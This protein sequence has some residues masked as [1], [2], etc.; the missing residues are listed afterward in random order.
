MEA[1]AWDAKYVHILNAASEN[2]FVKRLIV[3]HKD[4]HDRFKY[5]FNKKGDT[6]C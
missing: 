2:K 4:R 3:P 1:Y 5:L 6:K